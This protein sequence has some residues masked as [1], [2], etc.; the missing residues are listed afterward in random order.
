[1]RYAPR[2]FGQRRCTSFRSR[3]AA[4]AACRPGRRSAQ[5]AVRDRSVVGAPA[6]VA[7]AAGQDREVRAKG[8]AP[9]TA[10]WPD[11]V[12]GPLHAYAPAAPLRHALRADRAPRRTSSSLPEWDSWLH[13]C[14][15]RC[16]H[17]ERAGVHNKGIPCDAG[18]EP[19]RPGGARSHALD[20]FA[21]AAT[22][23]C[24]PVA[25]N[26]QG[27]SMPWWQFVWRSVGA[28]LIT[29]VMLRLVASD[30]RAPCRPSTSSCWC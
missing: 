13:A 22:T 11:R 9:V 29:V 4:R 6:S 16:V 27:V 7:A 15:K 3:L 30:R 24:L 14:R 18:I 21:R 19:Q 25:D 8:R 28:D 1:M 23:W 20:G 5:A 26:R 2:V 12:R 10:A 17:C